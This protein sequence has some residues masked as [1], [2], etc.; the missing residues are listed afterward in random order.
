M[1]TASEIVKN[2]VLVLLQKD[3]QFNSSQT[4][5]LSWN[6][7]A[8]DLLQYENDSQSVCDS[9]LRLDMDNPALIIKE[10]P[11]I[12]IQFIKE[13]A[14]NYVLGQKS[15]TIDYLLKSNNEKF[16]NEISFLQT[17]QLPII[18]VERK[19]IKADLPKSYER[20]TFEISEN[21]LVLATKKKGRDDLKAKMK[22]WDKINIID[23]LKKD[24]QTFP[25]AANIPAFVIFNKKIVLSK[26]II[27]QF[28]KYFII[29]A[30]IG[31]A[32]TVLYKTK[33]EKKDP[34]I[35]S[36]EISTSIK[37]K[38]V[39]TSFVKTNDSI[40]EKEEEYQNIVVDSSQYE[41]SAKKIQKKE[42]QQK[43]IIDSNQNR[44]NNK[45]EIVNVKPINVNSKKI[46]KVVYINLKG[47]LAGF[48]KYKSLDDEKEYQEQ[49]AKIKNKVNKY[50]FN[51]TSLTIFKEMQSNIGLVATYKNG[52]LYFY[53]GKNYYEIIKTEIP[54]EF[55]VIKDSEIIKELNIIV[56]NGI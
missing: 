37:S 34:E 2:I 1:N 54:L 3:T 35:K 51:G 46:Y 43:I 56:E 47:K 23:E 20:L 48:S 25:K 49:Y 26:V 8:L 14:E 55:N 12:Y 19:R 44:I 6:Q 21:N 40:I 38:I 11:K 15:E 52:S 24:D 7:F 30:T 13:L 50:L 45:K 36:A 10:L 28:L 4:A 31:I 5:H 27:I 32:S 16:K 29:A 17:M 41:L 33:F 42:K 18:N 22:E 53:D 39:D 9:I